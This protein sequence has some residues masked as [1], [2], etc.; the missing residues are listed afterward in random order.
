MNKLKKI[1]TLG[2]AAVI[3]L[4]NMAYADSVK[5]QDFSKIKIEQELDKKVSV[6]FNLQSQ[7]LNNTK[8]EA[9][10]P[11]IN[12][13]SNSKYEKEINKKISENINKSIDEFKKEVEGKKGELKIDSRI[14]GNDN[15]I[16]IIVEE[17]KIID[18]MA[19]GDSKII[20]YNID[21]LNNKEIELKDLFDKNINYEENI[22]QSIKDIIKEN[23]E[24]YF[25]GEDG[26]KSISKDQKFYIDGEGIVIVFEKGSIAPNSTGLVEFKINKKDYINSDYSFRFKLAPIWKDNVNLKENKNPE[27]GLF[28]VKF[29]YIPVEK[30]NKEQ[31]F[32]IIRVRDKK[33][34]LDN[35]EFMIKEDNYRY[36]MLINDKNIFKEGTKDNKRFDEIIRVLD[37]VDDLFSLNEREVLNIFD[38]V[39]VN[40]KEIKLNNKIILNDNKKIKLPF[41]EI[42]ENL[43]FKIEWNGKERLATMEKLPV[44]AGAYIDSNKYYFAKSLFDLEENAVLLN[45]NTYVPS[46]FFTKVLDG[47]ISINSDGILDINY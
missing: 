30:E 18:N 44:T 17:Y 12:G 7:E 8:L 24:L 23:K 14:K 31:D 42:G 46:E 32:F 6:E 5:N 47:D 2:L 39:I 25:E 38:K 10:I 26:F 41:R 16:S 4:S 45:G 33:D 21:I 15:I 34:K 19:N 29:V 11:V 27:K 40:N 35:D 13:L 9:K 28:E 20:I 3:S 43:G 1:T 37:G 22:N 36:T